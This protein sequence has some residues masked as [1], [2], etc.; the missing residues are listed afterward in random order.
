MKK[1]RIMCKFIN[2]PPDSFAWMQGWRR[3]SRYDSEKQRAQGLAALRKNHRDMM[4]FEIEERVP[5]DS[6][7][8]T[9]RAS[10]S[11]TTP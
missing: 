6:V 8:H 10:G 11:E 7:Q 9:G 2:V 3:W 4:I 1:Y 5:D